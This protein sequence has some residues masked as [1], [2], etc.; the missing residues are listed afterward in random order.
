MG[1]IT[2]QS[3]LSLYITDF[4]ANLYSSDALAPDTKEAQSKCWSNVPVK[5]TQNT[6]ESLTKDLTLKDVLDAIKALP[7][8]KAPGHEGVPME[9]FQEYANEVA[10]TLLKAFM[11]MLRDGVTLAFIN[12]GIITLI[13]K[14]GD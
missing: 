11:S 10:P 7:K 12:K 1:S 8:G 5:V 2:G 6:N 9:F 14:I 4:Y 13:P 3:D